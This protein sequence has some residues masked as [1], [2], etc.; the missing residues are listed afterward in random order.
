MPLVICYA[1]IRAISVKYYYCTYSGASKFATLALSR[2][3]EPSLYGLERRSDAQIVLHRLQDLHRRH[4]GIV[5]QKAI[6][7]FIVLEQLIHR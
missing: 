5:L 3:L 2:G 6:D 4:V 7:I 1:P